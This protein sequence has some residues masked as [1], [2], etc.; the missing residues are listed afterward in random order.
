MVSTAWA[1]ASL[2]PVTADEAQV[3]AAVPAVPE[4]QPTPTAD[5]DGRADGGR[6]RGRPA[7]APDPS[8]LPEGQVLAGAAKTS[9]LPRPQDYDGTWER[10]EA[11][12]ATLSENAFT[13]DHGR[14]GRGRRPPGGGRL[15]VAGEPQLHLH[16]RLRDRPDEPGHLVG[17]GA[18]P[19]GARGRAARPPGRRPRPR[20]ARRRGLLL[21]LRLQVRRLRHQAAHRP[22]R[23]R[24]RARPRGRGHRDRGDPRALLAGLH[25]RLGLR[26]RLVHEAGLRHDQVDGPRGAR[27]RCARP[28]SST[29]STRRAPFNSERRTPTARPRSSSSRGCARTRRQ[30]GRDDR[31]HRRLRRAS[32]DV[33]HQ[34]RRGPSRLARAVRG[35]PREALRR[36]RPALHDRASGTCRPPGSGTSTT[37]TGDR[38]G[39]PGGADHR[40]WAPAT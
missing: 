40:R 32:D 14:P 35:E 34:R 12:C 17:R 29:A 13:G 36:R 37:P 19:L 18:R 33:R 11:K 24:R 10:S 22:A 31:H 1:G 39:R 6:H 26:A 5:A 30:E 8:S 16:G 2:V 27:A 3:T 4:I 20:R 15:A 9:I 25:R 21:G 7:P 38:G 23:G 28:S